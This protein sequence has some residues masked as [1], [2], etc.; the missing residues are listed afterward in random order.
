MAM[1]SRRIFIKPV[2]VFICLSLLALGTRG[3]GNGNP[4]FDAARGGDANLVNALLNAGAD[5]NARDNKDKEGSTVLM[6]AAFAGQTNVVRTLIKHGAN[7]DART[8]KGRTALMWAAWRGHEATVQSLVEGGASINA[9]DNIGASAL[10]YALSGRNPATA[11]SLLT[12]RDINANLRRADG[13]N[14]LM[15]AVGLGDAK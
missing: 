8:Y 11:Q 6:V 7:M 9:Q 4:R 5:P 14:A 3:Q 13:V 15:L 2:T 10:F 1:T 12:A